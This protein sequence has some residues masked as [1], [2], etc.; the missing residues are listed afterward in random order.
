MTKFYISRAQRNRSDS[1]G[2]CC[3]LGITHVY[4]SH[5]PACRFLTQPGDRVVTLAVSDVLDKEPGVPITIADL[6]TFSSHSW[7]PRVRDWRGH[8][9]RKGQCRLGWCGEK[10]ISSRYAWGDRMVGHSELLESDCLA[11]NSLTS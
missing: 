7:A 2:K 11:S 1:G 10:H 8:W 3:N 9:E 4:I 6:V 5:P